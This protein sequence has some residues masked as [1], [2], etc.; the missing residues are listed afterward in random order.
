[1][2]KDKGLTPFPPF[3]FLAMGCALALGLLAVVESWGFRVPYLFADDWVVA[4]TITGGGLRDAI[5]AGH[6]GVPS[7]VQNA[8]WWIDYNWFDYRLVL[9]HLAE[10]VFW[11][12]GTAFLLKSF[13]AAGLSRP[14]SRG[15]AAFFVLLWFSWPNRAQ[16]FHYRFRGVEA[17]GVIMLLAAA[18]WLVLAYRRRTR[19]A[20][21]R[22]AVFLLAG[23]LAVAWAAIFMAGGFG[24]L[25]VVA[26]AVLL[27]RP[28][29]RERYGAI[30]V[31][32]LF[33]VFFH[34]VHYQPPQLDAA[35]SAPW[36]DYFLGF[37]AF[38]AQVPYMMVEPLLGA[39]PARILSLGIGLLVV[40]RMAGLA[41]A[42]WR[43]RADDRETVAMILLGFVCLV[44]LGAIWV[45]V[46][47][48]GWA[49]ALSDRYSSYSVLVLIA[50][51]L[52]DGLPA[53]G[54]GL[55]R[56]IG[57]GC[58]LLVGLLAAGH[59]AHG[60]RAAPRLRPLMETYMI[61]YTFE[62]P[63]LPPGFLSTARRDAAARDIRPALLGGGKSVFGSESYAQFDRLRSTP[64]DP[65]PVA[66]PGIEV[67]LTHQYGPRDRPHAAI[68]VAGWPASIPRA[69]LTVVFVDD[70][71]RA[72]GW[73]IPED[74]APLL[75]RLLRPGS[76]RPVRANGFALLPGVPGRLTAVLLDRAGEI[77]GC[78]AA[79]EY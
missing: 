71:G 15:L 59:A 68:A 9:P 62:P 45:R 14:A 37:S 5:L 2:I 30:V 55:P 22:N 29:P 58:L 34:A 72:L 17:T 23:S 26:I 42:T 38:V 67:G 20:S 63:F 32:A 41:W 39:L 79:I 4:R 18:I 28:A 54:R 10:L 69:P 66:S 35:R 78:S 36:T 52:T 50:L 48:H 60:I 43:G 31:L 6:N 12:A 11:L 8:L 51:A 27:N 74:R 1:M 73:A 25:P 40:T 24:V 19:D 64:L 49:Y 76:T 65:P 47:E 3:S 57:F 13:G 77:L 16:F 46:S 75:H 21:R 33:L 61:P 44:A 70:H 53:R 7:Y 56:P